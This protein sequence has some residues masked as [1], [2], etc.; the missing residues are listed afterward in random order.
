MKQNM[1]YEKIRDGKP[2]TIRNE[3]VAKIIS[4]IETVHAQ[5]P[6]PKTV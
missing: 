1:M 5:N 4:F 3:D 6:L 2:L